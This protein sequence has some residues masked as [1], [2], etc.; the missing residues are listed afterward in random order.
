MA[1]IK[2]Q[3]SF[4]LEVSFSDYQDGHERTA[5]VRSF[6]ANPWG[7]HDM[8]GNVWE[9]TS[10]WYDRHYYHRSADQDPPGSSSG[11]EKVKRGGSWYGY[12]G[13]KERGHQSLPDSDGQTGFRWA[14][15]LE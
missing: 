7:L 10:D 4:G 13:V 3:T 1:D 15:I 2:S 11:D 8:V 14:K 12:Q 6:E 5:P 9:W